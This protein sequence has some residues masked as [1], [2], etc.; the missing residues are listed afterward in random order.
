MPPKLHVVVIGAGVIG[1]SAA[2]RL[3][4]EGFKVT[5]IAQDLP[6]PF[7]LMHARKHANYASPWA[8]AHN[9]WVLPSTPQEERDYQ[10]A[11]RTFRHM[12]SLK[13]NN[14]SG[15]AGLTFMTG[16]EYLENPSQVYRDLT[17]EKAEQRGYTDFHLIKK[18]DLPKD[19]EWGCRYSTWC[20]NPMMYCCYLLRQFTLLGGAIQQGELRDPM[21]VFEMDSFEEVRTA[22]NC[23][24]WGFGDPKM[25]PTRGQLCIVA[26]DCDVTVTRQNADG[27]WV[28]IIP[29]KYGGGTVIGG[30]REPGN[31]STK[32]DE[33]VKRQMLDDIKTTYPPITVTLG[34]EK[35]D[36]R[37]LR[38]V[39]GRRPTREGGLRLEAERVAY[40]KTVVHAY[41]LG[42]R[43]YECSWGVAE[44]VLKLVMNAN[45]DN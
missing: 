21:E 33:E 31:W 3:Q 40:S 22:V 18:A 32:P 4:Q 20:V 30:T 36:F 12:E 9:R 43:G 29:R 15:E 25:S 13:Q 28:Y 35:D 23:S 38:D 7:E 5:I 24:G 8:G 41:G 44:E 2:L 34:V 45:V 10:F 19:V 6:G 17:E 39:V 16:I 27:S 42:G 26:S 37:V 14:A 1:L 11:L